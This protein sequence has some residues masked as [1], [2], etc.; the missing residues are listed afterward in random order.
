MITLSK[1][2][3]LL[4]FISGAIGMS[5]AALVLYLVIIGGNQEAI[6]FL[7]FKDT[8][9]NFHVY[10][11]IDTPNAYKYFQSYYGYA[12]DNTNSSSF[13]V[14]YMQARNVTTTTR[15]PVTGQTINQTD[16]GLYYCGLA[17]EWLGTC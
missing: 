12:Y 13:Y 8:D 7:T 16:L 2:N 3:S 10:C 9:F 1:S 6:P 15:D 11:P 17:R 14:V 4:V 5:T